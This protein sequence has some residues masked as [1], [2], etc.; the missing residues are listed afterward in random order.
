MWCQLS[1][2]LNGPAEQL[3]R[4]VNPV[5]DMVAGENADCAFVCTRS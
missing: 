4:V 1:T 5:A 3:V 2:Q